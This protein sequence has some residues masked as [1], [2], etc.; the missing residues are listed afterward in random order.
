MADEKL[1]VSNGGVRRL[2]SA[3]FLP[4]NC[5]RFV[6][7][8][9]NSLSYRLSHIAASTTNA[10]AMATFHCNGCPVVTS[11]KMVE[12]LGV[13]KASKPIRRVSPILIA[14]S[15]RKKAPPNGQSLNNDISS[16]SSVLRATEGSSHA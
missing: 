14:A 6:D 13:A 7:T 16:M 8:L 2:A 15:H 11:N 1:D 10:A 9:S 4:F 3:A 12:S 5:D